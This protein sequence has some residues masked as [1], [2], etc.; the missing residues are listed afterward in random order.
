MNLNKNLQ[1][2]IERARQ[3]NEETE[4]QCKIE[5]DQ[6]AKQGRGGDE[7]QTRYEDLDR[8]HQQLQGN[9]R[10]QQKVTAEVKQDAANFLRE[11][12]ALSERSNHNAE[13]EEKLIGQVHRLEE[14]I[15]DWR[16]RYTKVK[17]QLRTVR[18]PSISSPTQLP[19]MDQLLKNRAFLK[20]NGEVKHV[21]VTRFQIWIDELLRSA[22][23]S[24][25]AS[26]LTY[27]K[28]VIIAVRDIS[29]DIGRSTPDNDDEAQLLE[30]LKMR[31]SATANNLITAAKNFAVADGLSPV[32]L[33]DA[34]ASHLT[35][36]IVEAIRIVKIR[37]SL[38]GELEDD[39][40]DSLINES[41]AA[42]YGMQYGRGSIGDE[43]I[44]SAASPNQ[45]QL[46]SNKYQVPLY[47]NGFTQNSSTNGSNNPTP[48]QGLG[49]SAQ[50]I[51]VE[52][53]KVWLALL[54]LRQD[55]LLG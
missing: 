28:S 22:R 12:R 13:R 15:K 21:H 17:S 33:L 48:Q 44:Y 43:S 1:S 35:N 27:V 31:I 37:P 16:G 45:P 54:S 41:P 53:L 49:I 46:S 34:A 47:Q 24:E 52:E 14:E 8:A 25:S 23:V 40:D 20:Q 4:R 2:E 7:W 26:V 19:D 5:L 18:A 38:P 39:D 6:M 10:Q 9:L 42:P 36:S 50:D 11:M 55:V 32:S 51:E 3:S 30:N 29:Q